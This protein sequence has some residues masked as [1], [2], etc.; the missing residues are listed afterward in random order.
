MVYNLLFWLNS[1]LKMFYNGKVLLIQQGQ[2][3]PDSGVNLLSGSHVDGPV[4]YQPSF[5]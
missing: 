5:L 4:C 3:K 1:I 2:R